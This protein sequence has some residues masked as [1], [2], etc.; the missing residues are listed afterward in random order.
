MSIS[1]KVIRTGGAHASRTG[2]RGT[3]AGREPRRGACRAGSRPGLTA[4]E[5]WLA[6]CDAAAQAPDPDEEEP[7]TAAPWDYDLDAV[8]AKCRQVSAEEAAAAARAARLG[9][10]GGQSIP[11]ARR[12]PGQPGSARVSPGST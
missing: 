1:Q 8:I 6:W 9:L 7:D 10:P 2:S 3:R 11:L 5:D 12:G 4:R